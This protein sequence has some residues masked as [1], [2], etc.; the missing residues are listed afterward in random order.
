MRPTGASTSSRAIRDCA[1]AHISDI[2]ADEEYGV[3]EAAMAGGFRAALGVPMI[4]VYRA[5]PILWH[6]AGR[7]L[8]KVWP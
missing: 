1:I 6:A 4:V 5:S 7:W 8:G 2:L 3:Q